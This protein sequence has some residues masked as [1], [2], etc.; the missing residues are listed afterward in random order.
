MKQGKLVIS[1]KNHLSFI[2]LRSFFT[3]KIT[4]S[5]VS[6]KVI[7]KSIVIVFEIN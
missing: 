4:N 7:T 6:G 2:A 1:I 3:K 5:I